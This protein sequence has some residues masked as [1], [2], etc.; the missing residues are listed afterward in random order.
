MLRKLFYK[1]PL[2]W[3][4]MSREKTRLTVAIVGIAFADILMF[5]QFGFRSALYNA[6]VRPQ[7]SLQGDLFLISPQFETV[8]SVKSFSAQRL[9]QAAGFEGVTSV[10][11]LYIDSGQWRNPITH[12]DRRILIFGIDPANSAFKLPEV[13]QHLDDLK[14]LNRVLFDRIGRAE[15]GPIPELVQRSGSIETEV[16]NVLIQAAGIFSLGASFAADGNLITSESTFMKLFPNRRPDQIDIGLIRL[17]SDA[18]IE[19]VKANIQ[20][21]L[22]SDVLVLTQHELAAREKEYWANATPIGFIF[23]LGSIVAFIVGTVIVYQILY[24]DVSDHLPEYATLKAMGYSDR[25]L[26]L[27][28]FQ[29]SLI[30]AF[31]GF[32]PGCALSL[33]MYHFAQLA[34]RLPIMM[35]TSRA[36]VVLL[37]TV[38]MCFIS[39]GIAV[40]KLSKADP[41]DIF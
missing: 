25:Y 41:A 9:Y 28:I 29:E 32:I 31:I 5:V 6:A 7:Y 30:L 26:I 4:Q 17:K 10:S 12:K 39:G 2:A 19:Q 35:T 15:Y 16:N 14:M 40:N 37:L 24:A 34:T 20:R 13:N 11:Y 33:G 18:D 38:I 22:P 23:G 36:I 21:V 1:T 8:F 3:L 27:V